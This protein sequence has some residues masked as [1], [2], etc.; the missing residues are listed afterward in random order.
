MATLM[1]FQ[2][3]MPNHT[4]PAAKTTKWMVIIVVSPPW[5]MAQD[6]QKRNF[7]HTSKMLASLVFPL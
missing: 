1:L 4:S 2:N 5:W 3:R 6:T 7:R